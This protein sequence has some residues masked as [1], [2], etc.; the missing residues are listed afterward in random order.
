[1]ACAQAVVE[2]FSQ[3]GPALQE[4]LNQRAETLVDRLSI[5]LREHR[6]PVS[7]ARFGSMFRFVGPLPAQLLIPHLVMRGI[8]VP[9]GM[10]F[11]VSVAHD[12]NDL[13]ELE[14]A[15]KDSLLAMRRGGYIA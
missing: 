10:L 8:Y 15:V 1:M 9:E 12:D 5:W 13:V 11:F 7:I 3:D 6:M 4:R 2:R 14:E